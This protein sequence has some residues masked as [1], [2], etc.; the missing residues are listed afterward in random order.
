MRETRI[1]E[2]KKAIQRADEDLA[3]KQARL[4]ETKEKLLAASLEAA[5]IDR[6]IENFAASGDD[7]TAAAHLIDEQARARN[8]ALLLEQADA[9]LESEVA[10]AKVGVVDAE[11]AYTR[12]QATA[13]DSQLNEQ[14]IAFLKANAATFQKLTGLMRM[15]SIFSYLADGDSLQ[16]SEGRAVRH[17]EQLLD[18][19]LPK[20]ASELWGEDD[21]FREGCLPTK[22]TTNGVLI[23]SAHITDAERRLAR[24]HGY[25][26]LLPDEVQDDDDDFGLAFAMDSLNRA[27]N[28]IELCRGQANYYAERLK[29]HPE[30][31]NLKNGFEEQTAAAE[32][33]TSIAA[34]WRQKIEA[35]RTKVPDMRG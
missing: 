11:T 23:R 32:R 18:Y 35:H 9:Y 16:S 17:V 25:A 27:Q 20:V 33:Y 28:S 19:V 24:T 31:A 2:T 4:A 5:N 26:A 14:V 3:R 6:R 34:N 22:A 1:D 29:V 7:P 21:R 15:A 30:D 13:L 12:A 10:K 8:I